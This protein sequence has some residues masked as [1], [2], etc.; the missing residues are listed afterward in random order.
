MQIY[1]DVVFLINFIMDTFIFYIVS[2]LTGKN[3]KKLRLFLGGAVMSVLYCLLLFIPNI[4]VFYNIFAA[5]VIIMVGVL[6]TF[7]PS[8]C[9]ELFKYIILSSVAA[10]SIGGIGFALYYF[11]ELPTVV[12]NMID[13]TI[14]NFPI[15]LLLASTCSFYI[16]IK[17]FY[18]WIKR[19]A[20]NK[21]VFYSVKIFCDE[22][23]ISFNAL[24]DT[25]NS[26]QDPVSNSPVII[27]EYNAVEEFL[28]HR[29]KDVFQ[30]K[31]DNDLLLIVK[32]VEE[33]D[34]SDRLRIIPFKSIGK[35]N[36]MLCGF[37]PDWVEINTNDGV[38]KLKNVVIGIYN[39]KLSNDG[40][41]QG[42]LGTEALQQTYGH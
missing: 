18:S 29:L 37:R 5:I 11:T 4:N 1:A 31:K 33:G 9:K 6:I 19:T 38:L 21:Q 14:T 23:N 22:A 25:G 41:Y 2:K 42:L 39:F 35:Q 15:K 30:E 27:A 13:F 3:V 7:K 17:L 24:V 34:F 40:T 10:F 20:I 28:P 26:L 12:G 32:S 16:I 36:G 8:C